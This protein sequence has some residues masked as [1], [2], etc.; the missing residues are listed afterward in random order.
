MTYA[1]ADTVDEFVYKSAQAEVRHFP[2]LGES[3]FS[4]FN[5]QNSQAQSTVFDNETVSH[6]K[7]DDD[8]DAKLNSIRMNVGD[9]LYNELSDDQKKFMA[10]IV[11]TLSVGEEVDINL[12]DNELDE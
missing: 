8:L 3:S 7:T 1:T 6:V 9:D 5:L 10:G 11:G 2:G 12:F 4:V